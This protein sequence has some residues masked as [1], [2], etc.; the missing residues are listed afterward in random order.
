MIGIVICAHG[1]LADEMLA[2]LNFITSG[3]GSV[4]A[5][6]IDHN[7]EVAEARGIVK[8]AIRT[9]NEGSGVLVLTDLYGGTPSNICMSF[10]DD[11][12]MEVL[13]GV[14]LPILIKAVSMQVSADLE[15]MAI[16]LKEY[17]R[18]NIHLASEILK[19]SHAKS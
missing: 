5:V 4:T 19:G 12:K 18:E 10:H 1:R 16:K 14:N 17:G 7:I 6:A 13:A 11:F 8:E 9:A 2:A 3:A 15:T